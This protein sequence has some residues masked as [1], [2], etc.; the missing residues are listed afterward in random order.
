MIEVQHTL[1]E[2][3]EFEGQ[4]DVVDIGA[5]AGRGG[6]PYR[7]LL[8]AGLARVVGFEPDP[9]ALEQLRAQS[10]PR[11]RY[12]PYAVFDGKTRQFRVCQAPGM[13]SLLEPNSELL[14]YFHGFPE[15]ARVR[16]RVDVET[17]RL[18]DVSEIEGMDYLKIDVQGAELEIFRHGIEKLSDCLIV[19]TEVEFLPMYVGQP[20][21]SEVELFLRGLGFRF[22]RFAPL[23]SRMIQPLQAGQ[24]LYAG[25]SQ[26]FWADA[27]FVRDFT[28]LESMELPQLKKMA[29]ALHEI[30]G[31]YDLALRCLMACDARSGTDYAPAYA[32]TLS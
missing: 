9:E 20:L 12:L 15:W 6:S 25:L 1:A 19:H 16:E 5:R 10:G 31:S 2:T 30:Y 24:D 14:R 21:F 4:L 29:L 11:E 18:D 7:K 26:I 32:K 27:V 17:V 23:V 22:H 3:I 28:K 13:S 8:D